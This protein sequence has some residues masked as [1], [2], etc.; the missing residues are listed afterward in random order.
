MFADV[1]ASSDVMA[2]YIGMRPLRGPA[3]SR[4]AGTR[5]AW[6]QSCTDAACGACPVGEALGQVR[7]DSVAQHAAARSVVE[8]LLLDDRGA[9]HR[10]E[11]A[12]RVDCYPGGTADTEIMQAFC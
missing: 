3:L 9:L 1:A 2:P 4:D 11:S 6:L 5:L 8:V 7:R 12:P 10:K